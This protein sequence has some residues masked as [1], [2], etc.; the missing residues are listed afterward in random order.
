MVDPTAGAKWSLTESSTGLA[1]RPKRAAR[2]TDA[3]VAAMR[4]SFMA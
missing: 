4:G 1:A 3:E 2:L